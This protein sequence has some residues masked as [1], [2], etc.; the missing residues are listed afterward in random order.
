MP[1]RRWRIA[2]YSGAATGLGHMR[3]NLLIGQTIASSRLRADILM[4]AESRQAGAFAMP[5]H[6]DCLTLPALHRRPDGRIEAR[7][8][9]TLLDEILTL[10]ADVILSALRAFDPDVLIVD[11][12]PRGRLGELEPTLK[13]LQA[14]GRT[15]L[16]L[17][18]R[19]VLE[20]CGVRYS[21]EVA[22]ISLPS[23]LTDAERRVRVVGDGMGQ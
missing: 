9:D 6:M 22:S 19:D 15:R 11:F 12:F 18:L 20:E 2:L 17:G 13:Y 7:H 5:P 3:R 21:P 16:V 4:V 10:R 1:S 8:L 14:Q 23:G